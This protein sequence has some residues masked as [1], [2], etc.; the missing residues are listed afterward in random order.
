MHVNVPKI[1]AVVSDHPACRCLESGQYTSEG[2]LGGCGTGV[3]ADLLAGRHFYV[4]ALEDGRNTW[5]VNRKFLTGHTNPVHG[6]IGKGYGQGGG[7][8][9]FRERQDEI[10]L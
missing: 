9:I 1:H 10:E 2:G 6:R 7:A 8:L 4:E 5:M 3:D